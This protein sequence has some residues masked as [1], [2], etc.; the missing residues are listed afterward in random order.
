MRI[1]VTQDERNELLKLDD[2]WNSLT[3]AQGLAEYLRILGPNRY[4]TLISSVVHKRGP[5]ILVE[6]ES[7]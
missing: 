3:T 5:V 2:R 4:H 6:P 7:N 1:A